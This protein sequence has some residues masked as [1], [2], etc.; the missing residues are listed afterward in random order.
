MVGGERTGVGAREYRVVRGKDIR[1][2]FRSAERVRA[3]AVGAALNELESR[4]MPQGRVEGNQ[5]KGP[6]T[7]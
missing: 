3:V 4:G 7:P 6:N 2:V 1:D 5:L